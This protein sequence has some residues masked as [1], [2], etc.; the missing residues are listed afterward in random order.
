MLRYFLLSSL[1]AVSN[2]ADFESGTTL[3]RFAFGSCNKHDYPQPLWEVIA[4]FNPQVWAWLG[5]IVYADRQIAP[6]H[7]VE[8]NLTT[9]GEIWEAQKQRPEYRSFL[10]SGVQVLGTWDDHD[11]GL[12][13]AG[14][15]L[16]WKAT[17]WSPSSLLFQSS[18]GLGID[19][20][21]VHLLIIE[22]GPEALARFSR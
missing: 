13:N 7:W 5:D 16:E 11:Y 8:N 22:S 1:L 15:E 18:F 6:L 20:L 14:S 17:V 10:E 9:V 19:R 2:A 4:K 3:E 12:N 21:R